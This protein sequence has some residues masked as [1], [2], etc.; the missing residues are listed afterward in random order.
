M[1]NNLLTIVAAFFLVV[2]CQTDENLTLKVVNPSDENLI[3]VVIRINDKEVINFFE[4]GNAKSITDANGNELAIQLIETEGKISEVLVLSNFPPNEKQVLTLSEKEGTAEF[5]KRT[6][7]EI[8]V[9]EGGEWKWVTK[10]NGNEQYEYQGGEWKNVEALK[11][12]E[13]HTDHSFDIKY[14]GPGWESDKIAYRFYLDW[15]NA[16]DIFG[17]TTD[18]MVL[19]KIGLDGF[20][21]YH[22]MCEWGVDVLKVGNSL[23][24]GSIG[25]WAENKANRVEKTD[26]LYSQVTYNGNLES[27]ITNIYSGWKTTEGKTDLTAHLTIEAGSYLTKCELE[28][29]NPLENL[30][31]GIVKHDNTSLINSDSNGEW[32]Y[33]ATFGVQTL[34]NDNLGMFIFYKKNDLI[35]LTDDNLSHVVVLKPT[36]NQIT[37]YLG[38]VWE[39][40]SSGIKT[41]E[42]LVS[43]LDKELM[44]L[45]Q[46]VKIVKN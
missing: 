16:V 3:D 2:A 5:P 46:P 10:S 34:Q 18:E 7:A 35:E 1:K 36:D 32:A 40:D 27:K 22:E 14:E 30:C 23:G 19:Q 13:K 39:K 37:Y 33:M 4:T 42:G 25:H 45:N 43:F 24:L 12:D 6:Q 8:S 44:K 9:K 31:T 15:R 29:S 28:L 38:A 41:K 21:S 26:S 20:D 17:K 11:V